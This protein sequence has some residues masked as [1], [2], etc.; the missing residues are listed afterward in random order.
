[1]DCWEVAKNEANRLKKYCENVWGADC[2]AKYHDELNGIL[3]DENKC[4]VFAVD[5]LVPCLEKGFDDIVIIGLKEKGIKFS[6]NDV[7]KIGISLRVIAESY[8]EA[9]C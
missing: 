1:M 9:Y 3:M 4:L 5:V 7:K 8:R 2:C 6:M